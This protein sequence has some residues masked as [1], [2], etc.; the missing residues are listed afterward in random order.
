M[1]N[2]VKDEKVVLS[3]FSGLK[4]AVAQAFAGKDGKAVEKAMEVGALLDRA[5]GVAKQVE[6]QDAKSVQGAAK[7]FREVSEHH[8]KKSFLQQQQRQS[9]AA[10]MAAHAARLQ[11]MASNEKRIEGLTERAEDAI[12]R[13]LARDGG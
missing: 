9:A 11:S 6:E 10:T 12:T 13:E 1:A 3:E 4:G 8:P 2:L 7:L 5:R